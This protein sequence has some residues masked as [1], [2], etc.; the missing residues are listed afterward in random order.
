MLTK[1]KKAFLLRLGACG[2]VSTVRGGVRKVG[3]G[4]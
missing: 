4:W 2:G 1:I 3:V